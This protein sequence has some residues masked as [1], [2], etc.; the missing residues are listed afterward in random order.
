MPLGTCRIFEREGGKRHFQDEEWIVLEK[1]WCFHWEQ[2]R[3]R[4]SWD[5]RQ[6]PGVSDQ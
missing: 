2:R 3:H 1:A 6:G 4:I 5:A